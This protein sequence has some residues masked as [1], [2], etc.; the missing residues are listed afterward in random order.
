MSNSN[1]GNSDGDTFG[2]ACDPFPND[3]ANDVD[4]DGIGGDTDNCPSLANPG[5][6]DTDGDDIGDA[7]PLVVSHSGSVG[8]TTFYDNSCLR[9][10]LVARD[11]WS[12]TLRDVRG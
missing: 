2:D 8:Q 11:V 1:Q 9:H 7:L 5:Q 6:A 10:F 12:L 4:G 3:P